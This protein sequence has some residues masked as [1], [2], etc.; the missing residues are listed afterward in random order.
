MERSARFSPCRRF[1]YSLWRNWR[2]LLPETTGYVMFIGL[3]P[4][5]ANELNDDPTVRRCIAYAK[6][7]GFEGLCMTNLFAYRAT[8]PAEML[9]Q[10]DPIGEEND[11]ALIDLAGAAGIVI[12]AWGAHGT[13]MRRGDAV[14]QLIPNLHYLRLTK[15]GHPG[16]PLYLPKTLQP[17][18]YLP[19][20]SADSRPSPTAGDTRAR[21]IHLV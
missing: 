7:W 2:G 18:P 11:Q 3:N 15:D 1:R 17:I 13:H 5:T 10:P 6:T 20:T 4:S 19:I 12:A 21:T 9:A 8:D 14:R 16:H